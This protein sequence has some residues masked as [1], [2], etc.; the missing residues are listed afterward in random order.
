MIV[1]CNLRIIQ[2]SGAIASIIFYWCLFS[3]QAQ[4]LRLLKSDS[5]VLKNAQADV[6]SKKVELYENRLRPLRS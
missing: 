6:L 4:E 1:L 5:L 3:V 2:M